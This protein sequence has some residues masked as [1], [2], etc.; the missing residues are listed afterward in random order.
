MKRQ[1]NCSTAN[2]LF[3]LNKRGRIK[4][5]IWIGPLCHGEIKVVDIE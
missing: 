4:I 5:N 2:L 1:S 3:L